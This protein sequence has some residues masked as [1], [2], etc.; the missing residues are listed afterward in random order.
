VLLNLSVSAKK[1]FSRATA[2]APPNV[3]P[4]D[5]PLIP[6]PPHNPPLPSVT[7]ISSN[8]RGQHQSLTRQEGSLSV[9]FAAIDSLLEME[10][11]KTIQTKRDLMNRI[12]FI[13]WK[14]V[15]RC[16]FLQEDREVFGI[17]QPRFPSLANADNESSV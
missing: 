17:L 4:Q 1:T 10:L 2:A 6:V 13:D 9:Q 14:S 16:A 11:T 8:N 5:R 12:L 15:R 7:W 3:Q